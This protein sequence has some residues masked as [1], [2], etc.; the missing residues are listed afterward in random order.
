MTLPRILVH[1]AG[2]PIA[3]GLAWWWLSLPEGKVWQLVL[4]VLLA[5]VIVGIAAALLAHAFGSLR[6]VHRVLPWLIG[7]GCLTGLVFWRAYPPLWAAVPWLLA[8][9]G[10]Y[11]AAGGPGYLAQCR[12]PRTYLGIVGWAVAALLLPWL[13]V[14]WVPDVGP[15]FGSQATSAATR[16]VLATLLFVLSWPALGAFWMRETETMHAKS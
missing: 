4:S 9:P 14:R 15:S 5:I 13:L 6:R 1:L 16:L 12:Q 11:W 8:L 2:W 7:A 10:F 3:G